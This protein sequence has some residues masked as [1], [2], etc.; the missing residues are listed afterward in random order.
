[1]YSN[2]FAD[3][4]TLLIKRY[5]QCSAIRECK[6]IEQ[7][8]I[9]TILNMT[10]INMVLE[11]KLD[12]RNVKYKISA[13]DISGSKNDYVI[14][15]TYDRIG[16]VSAIIKDQKE[17]Q[18]RILPIIDTGPI[19]DVKFRELIGDGLESILIRGY[20]ISTGEQA[21]WLAIYKFKNTKLELIWSGIIEAEHIDVNGIIRREKNDITF[22]KVDST[23][24]NK[25]V[26]KGV[27]ERIDSKRAVLIEKRAISRE[28][29]WDPTVFKYLEKKN[30]KN[31][32]KN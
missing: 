23:N 26:L 13:A 11:D 20:G 28:F 7:Q 27:E 29:L 4:F 17:D 32:Y 21:E 22:V 24:I 12:I 10:D 8:I 5:H 1:M 6:K 19:R 30:P 31:N 14:K 9:E 15:I 18:Y 3:D 2:C 16:Y 25:I